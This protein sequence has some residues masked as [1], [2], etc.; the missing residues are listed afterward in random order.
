[1]VQDE[2]S[3]AKYNTALATSIGL[4]SRPNGCSADV[5]FLFAFVFNQRFLVISVSTT[6]AQTQ[7]TRILF[8][9]YSKAQD[10]VSNMIADFAA[11]YASA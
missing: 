8:L 3:D 2:S 7:F 6:A 11:T 10:F 1:M 9:A 5:I 4:P